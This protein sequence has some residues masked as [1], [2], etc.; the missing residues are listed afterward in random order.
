MAL[1]VLA[2]AE[3]RVRKR[4]GVKGRKPKWK[5]DESPRKLETGNWEL[6]LICGYRKTKR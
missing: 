2:T 6:D 3:E 5:I 4:L 1:A